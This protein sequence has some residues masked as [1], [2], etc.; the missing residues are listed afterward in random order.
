M[1]TLTNRKSGGIS[2]LVTA[3][4]D[5]V[6]YAENLGL[7]VWEQTLR[8]GISGEIRR[9]AKHGGTAGYSILVNARDSRTRKRFTVAHEIA[10]YLLHRD[11]IGDGLSDN[12][13]YR[14]GLTTL[15]EVQANKKAAEILMP[16]KLI[17]KEIKAGA[18]T[19]PHLAQRFDVSE[20]AMSIRL[21]VP[22]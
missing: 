6:A 5:V 22:S 21:G 7:K 4:V 10:H 18:I 20:Q 13:L 16:I 12:S 1:I 3:P 14:S 19:I 8:D 11:Q 2:D 15:A 17:E 9:D